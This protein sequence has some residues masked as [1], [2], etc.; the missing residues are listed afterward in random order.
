MLKSAVGLLTLAPLGAKGLEI[1]GR[2][3]REGGSHPACCL[4]RGSFCWCVAEWEPQLCCQAWSQALGRD[5]GRLVL[6]TSQ[7][8]HSK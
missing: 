5:Q 6:R 7:G 3:H 8:D 2:T 4:S 1:K